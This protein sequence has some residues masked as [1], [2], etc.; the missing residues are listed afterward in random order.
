MFRIFVP[1]LAVGVEG[2]K[3]RFGPITLH[4]LLQALH[5]NSHYFEIRFVYCI[6]LFD[7]ITD[8]RKYLIHFYV[9]G[10][11]VFWRLKL[12]NCNDG[13]CIL[14]NYVSLGSWSGLEL[15]G[16]TRVSV[17]KQGGFFEKVVTEQI[18]KNS[19]YR[20]VFSTFLS[21]YA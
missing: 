10:N 7:W 8:S 15:R 13:F 3:K 21:F 11:D 5:V 20:V 12:S 18:L 2:A 14:W 17:T 6:A 1:N 4:V 19:L 9:L 16:V